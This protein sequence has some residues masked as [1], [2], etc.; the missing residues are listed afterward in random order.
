VLA[1]LAGG[2]KH[3]Y[4]ITL[5]VEERPL[6]SAGTVLRGS[7]VPSEETEHLAPQLRRRR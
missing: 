1:S 6:G 5:D 3:G 2:P 7:R 4:A